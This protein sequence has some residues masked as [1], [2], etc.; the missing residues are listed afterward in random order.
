LAD[1]LD[2]KAALPSPAQ[3]EEAVDAEIDDDEALRAEAARREAL[4][5]GE[6]FEKGPSTY[7]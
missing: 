2:A 4:E 3:E 1:T 7:E 6:L 5:A